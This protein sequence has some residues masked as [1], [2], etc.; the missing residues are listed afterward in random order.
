VDVGPILRR[1]L[2]DPIG[3]VVLTSATMTAEQS[4]R[5]TRERLRL[6]RE[7]ADEIRL[8]APF[9]WSTQA[10]LYLPRDLPDPRDPRFSTLCTGRIRDLLTITEGRAFVLF[11]SHRA[12]REASTMLRDLPYPLLVQGAAPRAS[13]IDRFRSTS[14]AVLL[15]TGGFWEGVDVPGDA[16][17][18]VIIDKLPFAPPTDPLV[19]AR[20]A[21]CTAA[22]NDPFFD[23][24][25]PQAAIALR[26]GFGRLIRRRDD[27]GIV[28]VLDR[29]ILGKTYGR[30]FVA[31]L[32]GLL[33]R[34][35]SIER[36][37]RWWTQ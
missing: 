26:Q 2:F 24:Q 5:Y 9:D 3:S 32:P 13:L 4:F 18:Q 29:R 33:P 28:S 36:V 20:I 21:L 15:A 23:Y 16:L 37:R 27:R 35:A 1:E 19:R 25:V 7:I 12:L 17:S 22:G 11:T 10:I 30:A 6:D 34:T 31:S 14:G 8:D